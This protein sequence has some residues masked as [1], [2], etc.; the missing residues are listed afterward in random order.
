MNESPGGGCGRP[1]VLSGKR[2]PHVSC[3]EVGAFEQKGF[4]L[5][6]RQR[7]GE[8]VAEV[9]AGAMTRRAAVAAVR[10]TGE[11]GLNFGHR[12]DDDTQRPR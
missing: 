11:A 5:V 2:D 12:F 8:A 1:L 4:V 6:A 9:Q 10:V 3:P 7:V